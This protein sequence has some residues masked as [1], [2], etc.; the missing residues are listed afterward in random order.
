MDLQDKLSND[1]LLALITTLLGSE[2]QTAMTQVSQQ[3]RHLLAPELMRR[4]T[5]TRAMG[6]YLGVPLYV[7]PPPL[8]LARTLALAVPPPGETLTGMDF[9]TIAAIL[10]LPV[11]SL[12]TPSPSTITESKESKETKEIATSTMPVLPITPAGED[13]FDLVLKRL[14]STLYPSQEQVDFLWK[15]ISYQLRQRPV[16]ETRQHLERTIDRLT[17]LLSWLLFYR[18]YPSPDAVTLVLQD[19]LQAAPEMQP[20]TDLLTAPLQK[21]WDVLPESWSETWTRH[22]T[23]GSL[24]EFIRAYAHRAQSIPSWLLVLLRTRDFD[25]FLRWY[26][27]SPWVFHQPEPA[28][29]LKWVAEYRK[30][31]DRLV[32]F[33]SKTW[34]PASDQN[35]IH[36]IEMLIDNI[37]HHM[38]RFPGRLKVMLPFFTKIADQL[39]T[40]WKVSDYRRPLLAPAAIEDQ[41]RGWIRHAHRRGY[42]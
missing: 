32:D 3:F 31:V 29:E 22:L 30:T 13:L 12:P 36:V 19:V 35:A 24:E 37:W 15:A 16:D 27:R 18:L 14:A 1:I 26:I 33:L 40:A 23:P 6:E 25:Q 4:K 2:D 34:E 9:E 5:A 42:E 11:F 7:Q 21:A 38:P 8:S 17:R 39:M 20:V 28:D 10:G 41:I